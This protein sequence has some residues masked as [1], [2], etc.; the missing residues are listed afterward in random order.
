MR[1]SPAAVAVVLAAALFTGSCSSGGGDSDREA[2]RSSSSPPESVPAGP[3]ISL[4]GSDV[5]DQERVLIAG[6]GFAASIV[7][8]VQ[9]AADPSGS[10][11]DLVAI[12]DLTKPASTHVEVA[13]DGTISA[14]VVVRAAIGVDERRE[15]DCL[16][17]DCFVAATD[18]EATV[19]A[20]SAI[21][22]AADAEASSRPSLTL[23]D[24]DL[25]AQTGIVT[26]VGDGYPPNSE[27]VL[28]QCPAVRETEVD[29]DSGDC[30]YSHAT[31]VRTD[32]SGGFVTT[33]S[34]A[35]KFQRSAGELIDCRETPHLCALA[36]PWPAEL[37]QRMS[38][39][40]F[41]QATT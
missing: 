25:G 36:E 15:V 3:S 19:Y 26:V 37:A 6:E 27:V 30:L 18:G 28:L 22:W 34:V 24:L 1:P 21:P 23:T 20:T 35:S 16:D 14:N 41:D 40:T 29:V 38:R 9:C 31:S 12:C 8:L 39:V 7:E 32:R 2:D 11:A 13:E 4:E 5:T 10:D 17:V 33:A